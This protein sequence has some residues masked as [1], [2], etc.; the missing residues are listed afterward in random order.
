MRL[1]R[2]R[3]RTF[4]VRDQ[5]THER[6]IGHGSVPAAS[7]GNEQ[8]WQSSAKA[9]QDVGTLRRATRRLVRRKM[10]DASRHFHRCIAVPGDEE[11]ALGLRREEQEKEWRR[12]LRRQRAADRDMD[13]GSR[14]SDNTLLS[15][16]VTDTT[17]AASK[18]TAGIRTEDTT[19]RQEDNGCTAF[20]KI[21]LAL[22]PGDAIRGPPL[23]L[24][25]PTRVNPLATENEYKA[26]APQDSLSHLS[27]LLQMGS[28]PR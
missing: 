4:D 18:V 15:S 16:V 21:N 1:D 27:R 23:P 22:A 17:R 5:Q 24:E 19:W 12:L 2:G 6:T 10:R 25:P 13:L 26:I 28:R 9:S 3:R 11:I 7:E 14:V 8:Q 20:G